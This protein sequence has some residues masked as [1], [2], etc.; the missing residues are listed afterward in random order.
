MKSRRLRKAA[1]NSSFV[2]AR[3]VVDSLDSEDA[4]A[5]ETA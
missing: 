3:T 5:E 2:R 4:A 1:V